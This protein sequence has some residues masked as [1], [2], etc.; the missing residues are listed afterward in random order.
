MLL[1]NSANLANKISCS[2]ATQKES[3]L[4]FPRGGF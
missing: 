3:R 4:E 2:T 1:L